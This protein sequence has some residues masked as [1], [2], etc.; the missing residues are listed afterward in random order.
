MHE[1]MKSTPTLQRI[2]AFCN[3]IIAN[4]R[5]HSFILGIFVKKY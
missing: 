3:K 2:E 5:F 4:V 1:T